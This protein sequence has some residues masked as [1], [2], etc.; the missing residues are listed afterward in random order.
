[1]FE[2]A[3]PYIVAAGFGFDIIIITILHRIK[4]FFYFGAEPLFLPNI[5]LPVQLAY[6]VTFNKCQG[7]TLD[8]IGVETRDQSFSHG[9][10]YVA[11]SRVRHRNALC[12]YGTSEH[13]EIKN[14]VM[15]DMIALA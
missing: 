6:A 5:F 15:R 11:L 7:Q 12:F 13:L 8:F 14:V 9:Q 3:V 4:N 1:M 10:C 2:N